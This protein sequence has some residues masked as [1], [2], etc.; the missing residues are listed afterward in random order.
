MIDSY[1]DFKDN[2][3]VGYTNSI[4]NNSG[5]TTTYDAG[6]AYHPRRTFTGVNYIEGSTVDANRV[7]NSGLSFPNAYTDSSL[8]TALGYGSVGAMGQAMALAPWT[9]HAKTLLT[10]IFAGYGR[11]LDATV[12]P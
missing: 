6:A 8:A 5:G 9:G 4:G 1:C 2:L 12:L 11:T 3:I 10:T 7:T